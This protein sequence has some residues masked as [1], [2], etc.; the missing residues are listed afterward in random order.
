MRRKPAR[1]LAGLVDASQVAAPRTSRL[2][3]SAQAQTRPP[4]TAVGWLQRR[5]TSQ[6]AGAGDSD[7]IKPTAQHGI[8]VG[9]RTQRAAAPRRAQHELRM[10]ALHAAPNLF[11][12]D[13]ARLA[14]RIGGRRTRPTR[15]RDSCGRGGRG[16]AAMRAISARRAARTIVL[17]DVLSDVLWVAKLGR[18]TDTG[19]QE[20]QSD[21]QSSSPS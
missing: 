4:L 2:T 11:F 9:D 14:S 20:S 5:P 18:G 6:R 17:S 15:P 12:F 21:R 16:W 3:A 19:V 10:G 7:R 13:G 8:D 1:H